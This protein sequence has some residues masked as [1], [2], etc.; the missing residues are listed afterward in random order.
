MRAMT[1]QF[2]EEAFTGESKAH[3]KYMIFAEVAEKEGKKNIAKLFR[4]IAFADSKLYSEA[5]KLADQGKDLEIESVYICPVC[6]YSALNS[7]PD[8]CPVCRTKKE[9]FIKF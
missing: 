2:L 9:A 3:V 5:K 6:G 1:K 4:A 8:L 7:A